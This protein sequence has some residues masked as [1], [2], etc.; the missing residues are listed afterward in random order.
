MR[1]FWS[2]WI[3][4]SWKKEDWPVCAQFEWDQMSSDL[5]DPGVPETYRSQMLGS[6][7]ADHLH[8]SVLHA[9]SCCHRWLTWGQGGPVVQRGFGHRPV[10]IESW[11]V[12]ASC[13]FV[14]NSNEVLKMSMKTGSSW[15]SRVSSDRLGRSQDFILTQ[16][17]P[18]PG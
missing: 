14:D 7:K 16:A 15:T 3:V 18:F 13:T 17:I 11:N 4:A 6:L 8:S 5:H 10:I 2:I 12:G 1:N 9:I